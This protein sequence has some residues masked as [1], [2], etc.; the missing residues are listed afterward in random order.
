MALPRIKILVLGGTITMTSHGDDGVEPTITAEE[1][2]TSIPQLAD[3]AQ[4][5]P[6][7]L[8]MK[9]SASLN[10]EDIRTTHEAIRTAFADGCDGVVILQG[11]DTL[12]EV[13]FIFDLLN[14]DPRPIV[15]SGAMRPTH[16][17]GYDGPAN[18][19]A[20]VKVAASEHARGLG[21][22]VVMNDV[23][24]T[25]RFVI[26]SHTG[27]T[28]AFVSRLAGPI[29]MMHEGVPRFLYHPIGSLPTFQLPDG[30]PPNVGL[31]AF[32]F[33]QQWPFAA[34]QNYD[35][36]VLELAGSG[37]VAGDDVAAFT[38]LANNIPTVFTSR[39]RNGLVMEHTYGYAGSE[40]E[41]IA[42]GLIPAGQFDGAK[43]RIITTLALWNHQPVTAEI[44]AE[45]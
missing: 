5:E 21:A 1:L 14:D 35:A 39:A 13:A 38:E 10:W 24:H 40:I 19:L 32:A 7:T 44:F 11:T 36:V 41:L 15:V 31:F 12:E 20:S 25:A 3:V 16:K 26:K 4:V 34:M 22:L 2:V 33:A 43:A 9:P 29:G 45:S 30:Q 18:L 17:P 42:A 37:H 27:S 6:T 28:N 23:I 8:M